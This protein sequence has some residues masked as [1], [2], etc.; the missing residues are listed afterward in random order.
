MKLPSFSITGFLIARLQNWRSRLEKI[1]E[2]K[3][4]KA[5]IKPDAMVK[6]ISL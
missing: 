4:K 6:R 1:A 2:E 3:A 5:A